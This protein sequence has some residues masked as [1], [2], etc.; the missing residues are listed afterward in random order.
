VRAARKDA[1]TRAHAAVVIVFNLQGVT[2]QIEEARK[3]GDGVADKVSNQAKSPAERSETV[4]A[5]KAFGEQLAK[6]RAAFTGVWAF[7]WNMISRMSTPKEWVMKG[8]LSAPLLGKI[9]V[10]VKFG[11]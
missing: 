7:V 9:G 10:E 5:A 3:I 2:D 8:E 11:E 1:R 4:L 6:S